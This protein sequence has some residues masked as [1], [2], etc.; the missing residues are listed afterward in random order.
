MKEQTTTETALFPLSALQTRGY[1]QPEARDD[2]AV[3]DSP[4]PAE[5]AA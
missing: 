3:E 1:A 2:E 5:D 4:Q